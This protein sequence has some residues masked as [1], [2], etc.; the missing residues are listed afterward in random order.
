M[1]QKTMVA[2]LSILA[3]CHVSTATA[4]SYPSRLVRIAGTPEQLAG[5]QARE[6]E[7]WARIVKAAGMEPQ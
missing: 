2:A 7:K 4:D 5:H 3:H 6:I 1:L